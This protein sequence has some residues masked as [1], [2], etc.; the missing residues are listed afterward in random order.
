[1]FIL[2]S[3][4]MSIHYCYKCIENLH[5]KLKKLLCNFVGL[6]GVQFWKILDLTQNIYFTRPYK[7]VLCWLWLTINLLVTS[8]NH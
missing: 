3:Y 7:S 8:H 6:L 5:F 2:I 4:L 1:M